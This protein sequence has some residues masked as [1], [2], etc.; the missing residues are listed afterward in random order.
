MFSARRLMHWRHLFGREENVLMNKDWGIS[1]IIFQFVSSMLLYF[2]GQPQFEAI[3]FNSVEIKLNRFSHGFQS[4]ILEA[5]YSIFWGREHAS[6]FWAERFNHPAMGNSI[7]WAN[8]N[9]T[10][11][12]VDSAWRNWFFIPI[13]NTKDL[14]QCLNGFRSPYTWIM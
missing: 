9:F 4:I 12:S 11:T 2:F 8:H 3:D 10:R 7:F 13:A 6:Q 5:I 14:V 1:Q